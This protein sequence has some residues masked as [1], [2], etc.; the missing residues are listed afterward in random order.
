MTDPAR[1]TREQVQ[2]LFIRV[3]RDS[4][5]GLDTAHAAAIAAR[6]AGISP[7]EIWVAI[8]DLRTMDRIACGEHPA[9]AAA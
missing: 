9:A 4:G 2:R 8:G 6:A 3:C 1:P 5:F 7:L